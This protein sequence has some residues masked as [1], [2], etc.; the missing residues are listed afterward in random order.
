MTPLYFLLFTIMTE[1]QDHLVSLLQ[2]REEIDASFTK[3]R[4]MYWKIQGAIEYLAQIGVT[5]PEP[6]PVEEVVEEKDVEVVED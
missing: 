4:E 5:L 3:N 1:Q 2:Q 6:E